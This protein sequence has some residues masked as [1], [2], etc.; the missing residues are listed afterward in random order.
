MHLHPPQK[1][2]ELC[3][4][5]AAIFYFYNYFSRL[6]KQ[7]IARFIRS[8][9][10]SIHSS[11]TLWALQS[12]PDKAETQSRKITL[13]PLMMTLSKKQKRWRGSKVFLCDFLALRVSKS[14]SRSGSFSYYENESTPGNF[15]NGL[16]ELLTNIFE[17]A[18]SSSS[19]SLFDLI[20]HGLRSKLNLRFFLGVYYQSKHGMSTNRT[21]GIRV[22]FEMILVFNTDIDHHFSSKLEVCTMYFVDPNWVCPISR[23]IRIIRSFSPFL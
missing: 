19:L 17:H 5:F 10:F 15:R 6:K 14:F 11:L 18:F 3:W 2:C 16:L 20:C 12:R 7:N 4:I 9:C 8:Q 1:F 23:E 21:E 22:N 13:S